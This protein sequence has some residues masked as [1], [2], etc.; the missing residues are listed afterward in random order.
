VTKVL[1]AVAIVVIAAA[2][3][4]RI[5][6]SRNLDDVSELTEGR[7]LAK[8]P[9]AQVLVDAL[10]IPLAAQKTIANAYQ[11]DPQKDWFQPF[12]QRLQTRP[13]YVDLR[14]YASF[15]LEL[16]AATAKRWNTL[17]GCG[18]G[19]LSIP[20]SIVGCPF[21]TLEPGSWI[22][23]IGSSAQSFPTSLNDMGCEVGTIWDAD[24]KD[25]TNYTKQSAANDPF[26]Q[27]DQISGMV[28]PAGGKWRLESFSFGGPD[29]GFTEVEPF[30]LGFIHKEVFGNL[31][32]RN[33]FGEN[34]RWRSYAS[35]TLP[36][37]EE[38]AVYDTLPSVEVHPESR[39]DVETKVT[40]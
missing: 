33:R 16:T 29:K 10:R 34:P 30:H 4:V 40:F 12:G 26:H 31:T 14:G 5:V 36:G 27:A 9:S 11:P 2:G 28:L 1:L 18:Q 19:R 6:Y 13:N 37:Q 17:F 8:Y 21:E 32:Q 3:I 25:E 39:L 38:S 24:G 22:M 35:C 7:P 20:E 15:E 23:T